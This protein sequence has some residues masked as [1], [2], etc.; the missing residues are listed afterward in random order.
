LVT[1]TPD[2]S[3]LTAGTYDLIATDAFG[4][5]D[6]FQYI[7]TSPSELF[8]TST[9]SDITCAG[10]TSIITVSATG[11]TPPYIGVG[12]FT[13]TQAG[14]YDYIVTDANGC[15]VTT[16]ITILET[17]SISELGS[18]GV[19][20]Y[21]NPFESEFVIEGDILHI[22]KLNIEVID[23]FGRIVPISTQVDQTGLVVFTKEIKPGIYYLKMSDP[24]SGETFIHRLVSSGN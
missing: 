5:S 2:I 20:V 16:S 8:A 19:K 14:D 23:Q 9:G 1:D 22:S 7:L 24:I 11:G 4:C 12:D 3:N 17:T 18:F 15:S 6:Q 10:C 13:V 21:P